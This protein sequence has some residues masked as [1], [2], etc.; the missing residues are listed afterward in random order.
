MYV[1]DVR[2][3]SHDL[4]W[5]PVDRTICIPYFVLHQFYLQGPKRLT[6]LGNPRLLC[7]MYKQKIYI[8]TGRSKKPASKYCKTLIVFARIYKLKVHR[9]TANNSMCIEALNIRRS[10][11][12]D[13]D[14]LREHYLI[15]IFQR[16]C[17]QDAQ[18]CSRKHIEGVRLGT[19]QFD[20][21]AMIDKQEN[22][23]FMELEM[24]NNES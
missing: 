14:R 18:R 19:I 12:T 2:Q 7:T 13:T 5:A 15:L 10:G 11:H 17:A 20:D 16:Y 24:D 23:A 22:H 6:K 9:Q 4:V 3:L 8:Y 1:V 21:A